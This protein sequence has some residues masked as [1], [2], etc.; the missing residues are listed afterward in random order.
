VVY[1]SGDVEAL[2]P[3]YRPRQMSAEDR[4]ALKDALRQRSMFRPMT[5]RS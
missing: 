3:D 1:N 2:G 5:D 4:R